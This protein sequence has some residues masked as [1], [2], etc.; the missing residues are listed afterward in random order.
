MAS[1]PKVSIALSDR[2][3]ALLVVCVEGW[4]AVV[5]QCVANIGSYQNRHYEDKIFSPLMMKREQM[6][7]F[8]RFLRYRSR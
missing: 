6:R 2:P 4:H 1:G 7:L 5:S 8:P 3:V